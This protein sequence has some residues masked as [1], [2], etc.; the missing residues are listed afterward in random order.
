MKVDIVQVKLRSGNSI[1]TCYVDRHVNVGDQLTLKN[2]S[3][4]DMLWTVDEVYQTAVPPE[5][6]WHAGGL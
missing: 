3:E 2:S 5:R 4:P 1:R 6:G